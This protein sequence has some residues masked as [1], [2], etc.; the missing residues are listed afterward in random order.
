[1][2]T[3]MSLLTEVPSSFQS[4]SYM[5]SLTEKTIMELKRCIVGYYLALVING[6]CHLIGHVNDIPRRVC[7][8]LH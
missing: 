3:T 2:F 7:S 5:L 1:M 6:V 4:N 8:R